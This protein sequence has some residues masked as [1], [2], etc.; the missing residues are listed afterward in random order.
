MS[1]F[2]P[3]IDWDDFSDEMLADISSAYVT[4]RSAQKAFDKKKTKQNAVALLRSQMEIGSLA[5]AIHQALFTVPVMVHIAGEKTT[6]NDEENETITQ[7]CLRCGSVLQKWQDGYHAVTPAGPIPLTEE[8]M[9]WWEKGSIV[10][11]A[12]D[13]DDS[14]TMYLIDPKRKLE[15][16]E[17]ECYS[18]DSLGLS[19]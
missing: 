9:T 6:T 11:K 7:R 5:G 4:F 18:L 16:H 3:Y 12:G 10:A 2:E 13:E 17:R 19:G 8:D 1:N 15:K 14:V